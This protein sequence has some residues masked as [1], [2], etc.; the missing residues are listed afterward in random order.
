[1][2]ATVAVKSMTFIKPVSVGDLVSCYADPIATGRTS[3]TIRVE[4]W[5]RRYLSVEDVLVATAEIVY[6]AID[7]EGQPRALSDVAS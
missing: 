2:V 7:G 3:I 4:T 6:V 5:A 1:M